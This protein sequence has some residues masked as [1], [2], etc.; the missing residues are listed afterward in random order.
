LV[1]GLLSN[2]PDR[3]DMY[4]TRTVSVAHAAIRAD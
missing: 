2:A 4:Y 3:R 1:R